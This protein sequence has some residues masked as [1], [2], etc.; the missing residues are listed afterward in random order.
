MENL[1][2][3]QAKIHYSNNFKMKDFI[4]LKLIFHYQLILL[5]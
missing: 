2:N 1:L 3:A 5:I 4:L